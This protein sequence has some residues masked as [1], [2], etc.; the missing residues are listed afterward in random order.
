[1]VLM[2]SGLLDRQVGSEL[3]ISED[4]VTSHRGQVM[5]K[6]NADSLADLVGMGARLRLDVP[7]KR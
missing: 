4:T 1:M 2:T 5:R 6:V 3:G 7:S